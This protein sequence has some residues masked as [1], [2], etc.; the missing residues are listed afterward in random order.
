V[1]LGYVVR[2]ES[3]E[4]DIQRVLGRV[5]LGDT[6][7]AF[8]HERYLWRVLVIGRHLGVECLYGMKPRDG[9]AILAWGTGCPVERG[10]GSV[11]VKV[12]CS[13]ALRTDMS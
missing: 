9:G 3:I 12:S 2:V 6:T 5:L 4:Q 10:I 7:W 8:P 11:L 13:T 1:R